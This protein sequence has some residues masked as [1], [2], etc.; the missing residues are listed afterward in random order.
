MLPRRTSRGGVR[1]GVTASPDNEEHWYF[2]EVEL[3]ESEKRL[4]VAT[5]VKIGVLV[6][7]NTHVYTW[8][9]ESY[10]QRAGGPIGLCSTRAV[11]RVVMN[12][13]D[14]RWID[15]CGRNNIKVDKKNKYMEDI[16]AFLKDG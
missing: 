13:W 1:P 9:G 5:V 8:N 3:T 16:R 12:E 11:A 6:M 15:L 4:I 2:P 14:A 7:M 10:L